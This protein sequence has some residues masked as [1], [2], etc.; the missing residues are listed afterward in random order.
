M[1][2]VFIN[3]YLNYIEIQACRLTHSTVPL[4]GSMVDLTCPLCKKSTSPFSESGANTT[5]LL[6]LKTVSKTA[7]EPRTKNSRSTWLNIKAHIIKSW[8][9]DLSRLVFKRKN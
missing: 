3:I 8:T 9:N 1:L 4:S 2:Y 7:I 6:F 5:L